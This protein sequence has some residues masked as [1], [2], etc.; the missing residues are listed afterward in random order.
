MDAQ[1]NVINS[2]IRNRTRERRFKSAAGQLVKWKTKP[3]V[4]VLTHQNVC[5]ASWAF[6]LRSSEAKI[7]A[8]SRRCGDSLNSTRTPTTGLDERAE[9]MPLCLGVCVCA[10]ASL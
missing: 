10:D 7:P 2:A 4:A 5:N 9:L 3:F 6:C 1:I 8:V